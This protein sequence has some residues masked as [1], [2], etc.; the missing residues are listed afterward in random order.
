MRVIELTLIAGLFAAPAMAQPANELAQVSQDW[1]RD[2]QAKDL[3]STLSL[4]TDDAV[5]MDAS[6]AHVSGKPA[7]KQLFKLVLRRYSAEPTLHSLGGASSGDLGYDWGDYSEILKPVA[8]PEH[9]V[10]T[11]G[12]YLVILKRVNGHWLIANQMWTGELPAPVKN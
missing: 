12:T 6:G 2:W 3:M 4:Y 11:H 9:P 8:D 10:Q 1:A 7:L 5:F